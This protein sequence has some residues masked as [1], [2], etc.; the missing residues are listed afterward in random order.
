MTV[1]VFTILLPILFSYE[2]G[3]KSAIVTKIHG[4]IPSEVCNNIQLNIV[5]S[6]L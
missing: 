5:A 3:K 6:L 4:L 2:R 1:K